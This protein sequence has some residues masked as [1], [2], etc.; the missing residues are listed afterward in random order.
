MTDR[1]KPLEELST[2]ELDKLLADNLRAKRILAER[3]KAPDRAL[4]KK[5]FWIS[6]I[7]LVVSALAALFAFLTGLG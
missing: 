2:E 5:A 1:D 6:V 4:A 7:A 3:D